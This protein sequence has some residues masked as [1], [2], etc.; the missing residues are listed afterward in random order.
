M[1]SIAEFD[2]LENPY[3]SSHRSVDVAT[4]YGIPEMPELE[5]FVG[6][7]AGYYL[8]KWAPGW[9]ARMATWA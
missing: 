7:R 2:Q 5:V 1:P 9:R 4:A 6:P 8:R 3:Q